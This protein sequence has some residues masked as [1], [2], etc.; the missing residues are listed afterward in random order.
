MCHVEH[1][2]DMLTPRK[3]LPSCCLELLFSSSLGKYWGHRLPTF[4]TPMFPPG[5]YISPRRRQKV[6]QQ[7]VGH[8]HRHP[9]PLHATFHPN[10]G[11][12]VYAGHSQS[13][14]VSLST[15]IRAQKMQRPHRPGPY[16][17]GCVSTACSNPFRGGSFICPKCP[18]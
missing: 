13:L 11:L 4:C 10:T 17:D 7:S 1:P 9:T 2:E 6:L 12:V 3:L 18:L 15:T 14:C 8:L 5:T 16:L